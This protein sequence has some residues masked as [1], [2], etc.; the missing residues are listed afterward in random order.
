M[1]HVETR[2]VTCHPA[3]V[4]FPPLPSRS[5][6]SIHWRL[7]WPRHCSKCAAR[8]QGCAYRSGLRYKHNRP[9]WDSNLG[10]VTPQSGAQRLNHCDL[11]RCTPYTGP[12]GFFIIICRLLGTCDVIFNE[13]MWLYDINY[14]CSKIIGSLTTRERVMGAIGVTKIWMQPC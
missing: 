1:C 14:K 8:A 5:W 10:S 7:S 9:R 3:E 12:A 2:S 13:I 4:T 6:Y 11:Q